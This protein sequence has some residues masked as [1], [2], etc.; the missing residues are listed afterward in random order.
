MFTWLGSLAIRRARLILIITGVVVAI[1]GVLATGAMDKLKVG[2]FLDPDAPSSEAAELIE[3]RFGG[4]ADLIVLVE[5]EEGATVDSPEVREAGERLTADL[6][7]EETLSN[8]VSYWTDEAPSLRSEDGRFGV[9]VAHVAGDEHEALQNTEDL[10]AAY[11]G[12]IGPAEV[13]F[14][15]W[16][17]VN[18]DIFENVM[19][20]LVIAEAIAIPLTLV[21]LLAAFGSLV[22]AALPLA[23]GVLAIVGTF[24]LLSL[25]GGFTDVSIFSANLTTALGLGL[26]IDYALLIVA[27]FRERLGLGESVPDALAHTVRTAGR[28]ILFSAVIVAAALATMLLFPLYF[29]RSFAYAG[30]GV[31]T[32]AA[33]AA[34]FVV[35]ALLALLGERINAG[36]LP[37]VTGIRGGD[38]PFWGRLARAV[39]R[40]PVLALLPVVAGMVLAASPLLGV[41]FS[42]PDERVL[43]DDVA[44]R[45]VSAV[46]DEGFTGLDA[47]ALQ[48][49]TDTALDAPAV[50]SLASDISE[51]PGVTRVDASVGSFAEGRPLDGPPADA[52]RSGPDAEW[53]TVS[54][55][56]EPKS[57]EAT[58]LVAD[59]RGLAVPGG[60]ELLVGGTDAELVDTRDAIGSR[61]VLAIALITLV[62]FLVLFLFT[63]SVVQPLRALV[64]NGL[65]LAATFGIMV[66]I[67]QEGHL[68]GLLG[69]TPQ[70]TDSAMTVLV[71]CVVFGLAMD[72][73][74]FVVA[75]IKELHDQGMTPDA[76]VEHG[77]A[78]TGRIV[79][80]AAGLLAVSF[81]AFGTSSISFVQMFGIGA[82]LAILLDALLIRGVLVPG[83]L[84][85]LGRSA[86]WLPG[87]LR[88]VYARFG[89]SEAAEPEDAAAGDR[90][91]TPA[92]D[93][94]GTRG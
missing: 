8:V 65:G 57:E 7:G 17:G 79:T 24:G 53:L 39:R 2:G 19:T 26:G 45:E 3:E 47:S 74:V 52:E 75:R 71:F 34:L 21:L 41:Q 18:R 91:R 88:G 33:L 85:L 59:L 15:G 5:A 30:I 20:S 73:E 93:P 23:I 42:T 56:V 25:L 66:W 60:G 55:S 61:L 32:I 14:G 94:V 12:S 67:F 78:R 13:T 36:R 29:L 82:G 11:A 38:A 50:E 6:T 37:W 35:P 40:R 28:T 84:A 69:F 90:D 92:T 86:W 89:L 72:Y 76:A 44:S 22:A 81:L 31:V 27:R 68:S 77:L 63:G 46:L 48:V 16:Q 87:P 83:S 70:P 4:Q 49:V 1:S 80:T 54:T 43:R 64:L 62:T 51:R 10:H 9:V 58:D